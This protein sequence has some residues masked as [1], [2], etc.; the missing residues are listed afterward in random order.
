MKKILT[1]IL[2][3]GFLGSYSESNDSAKFTFTLKK[4]KEYAENNNL[5]LSSTSLDIIKAKKKVWESIATGLPHID[6]TYN[7]SYILT[8]PDIYKRFADSTSNT[9][10]MK[11]GNELTT[12]V[13]QLI[14]SGS[15]IVGVQAS[16]VYRN[17]S[18]LQYIKSKDE[19]NENVE[20]SYI[21]VLIAEANRKILINT[22][23]NTKKLLE[24][25]KAMLSEGLIEDTDVDQLELS[26]KNIENQISSI[27]SQLD[28]AY[29]M[30]KYQMG[31]D[32]D[33]KIFL[34][35]TLDNILG[36]DLLAVSSQEFKVD[37]NINISLLNLQVKL[38]KLNTKLQLAA[39]LPTVSGFYQYYKNLNDKA[40]SFTPTQLVGLKI[41]IPIFSGGESW[42]KY[43][44]ADIEVKQAKL[45]LIDGMQAL[46]LQ[47]RDAK[48]S[49]SNSY[50]KYNNEKGNMNLSEKIYDK[51]LIKYK[52]GV[53]SS[54]DLTQAQNQYLQSQ[55][56]Y[57]Q[58]IL[59]LI[60]N[61]TKL[62]KLLKK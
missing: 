39:Y 45:D 53:S 24:E 13:S 28:L 35:E 1:G 22:L 61:K 12:T 43:K 47:Y 54:L 29:W 30:L 21:L 33:Q 60:K 11:M 46:K 41:S 26:V 62:E 51:T 32:L 36:Q 20:N 16:K 48:A 31:I 40:L 18:K 15:Y 34:S 14:F 2:F 50:L 10:D 7:F 19:L 3:L 56:N 6:A 38:Q 9:N 58:S 8:L 37:D 52:E 17:L 49:Y 44:Q 57:F 23:E 25:T 59:E 5:K 55:G 42:M 4:A 27:N